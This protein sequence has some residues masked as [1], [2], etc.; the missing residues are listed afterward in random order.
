MC[1]LNIES[2]RAIMSDI[3]SGSIELKGLLGL[4]GGM[5]STEFPSDLNF[6]YLK[7]KIINCS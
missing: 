4:R 5:R 2:Y 1:C 6:F 7:D 3:G